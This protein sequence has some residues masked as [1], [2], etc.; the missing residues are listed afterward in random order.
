MN[1]DQVFKQKKDRILPFEFNEEVANVFDDMVKRS[2]PFY[3]EIHRLTLDIVER[4]HTGKGPIIDL[5]CSTGTTFKLI[6]KE[7]PDQDFH[8][9][10]ID[11][12]QAMLKKAKEKLLP[13][14]LKKLELRHESM[15]E[16]QLDNAEI[17]ILNYTLQ[18]LPVDKRVHLL[19]KIHQYLSPGGV[20]LLSEKI[21]S[22]RSDM[23]DLITNLYYD[24]KRR[25]G[26]SELEISQK[27]EALEN[28]LIPLTPEEQLDMLKEAGFKKVEMLFRWY[29]FASYIGIK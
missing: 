2:V 18:F 16:S 1:Q 28:I 27:R 19:Q 13:L 25:N 10:G 3:E 5:G 11:N 26:Y 4:Y 23:Q 9:I 29:N 20:M 21:K 6:T 12:S 15:E 24:F 7:F 8:F 14:K 17:V 22:P